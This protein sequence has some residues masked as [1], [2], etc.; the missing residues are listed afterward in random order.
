MKGDL[1]PGHGACE[2]CGE[3]NICDMCNG[4]SPFNIEQNKNSN[5]ESTKNNGLLKEINLMLCDIMINHPY[6]RA[7]KVGFLNHKVCEE[8]KNK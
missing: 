5:I 8:I 4:D 1:Y 3:P 6:F 2:L 7:E